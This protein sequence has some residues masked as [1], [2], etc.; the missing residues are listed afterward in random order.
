VGELEGKEER[1]AV[2]QE[3]GGVAKR[4]RHLKLLQ[5]FDGMEGGG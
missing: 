4:K 5:I 2:N 3:W 1:Q